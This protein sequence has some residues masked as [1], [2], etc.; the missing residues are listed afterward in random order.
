MSRR[1][2]LNAHQPPK[3]DCI[4]DLY[5]APFGANAASACSLYRNGYKVPT[6]Y[7]GTAG[8]QG[9]GAAFHGIGC[10][11]FFS[12]ILNQILAYNASCTKAWNSIHW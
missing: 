1:M 3:N 5:C 9:D 10:Y 6:W 11:V 7:K 8:Q 2:R 4:T 12:S